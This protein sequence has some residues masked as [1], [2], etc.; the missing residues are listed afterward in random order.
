MEG[1]EGKRRHADEVDRW[2]AARY[3]GVPGYRMIGG[4]QRQREE[5]Q[6]TVCK[7][8]LEKL[9]AAQRAR[10]RDLERLMNKAMEG[11]T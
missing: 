11:K 2:L 5:T 6:P 10:A 7:P 9:Y 3:E 8:S 4:V 1:D